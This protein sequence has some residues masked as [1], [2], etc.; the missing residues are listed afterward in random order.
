MMIKVMM[1][2]MVKKNLPL[3]VPITPLATIVVPLVLEHRE[4]QRGQVEDHLEDDDG[5]DHDD[6]G[7]QTVDDIILV[8]RREITLRTMIKMIMMKAV[9]RMLI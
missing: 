3:T 5:D 2:L 8:W 9:M 7:E 4:Y 6:G 1:M